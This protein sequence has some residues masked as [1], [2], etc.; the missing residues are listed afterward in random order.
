MTQPTVSRH[1][2][3]LEAHFAVPL[4]TRNHN[5][6]ALT[7]AGRQLADAVALGFGHIDSVARSLSA[8]GPD[9]EGVT[10]GCS[11]GFAS[12]WLIPR[13][14][15]LRR[16]L[17]GE[18]IHVVTSDWIFGLDMEKTDIVVTWGRQSWTDRPRLPLFD[19]IVYPVCAPSFCKKHPALDGKN[20]DPK[21]LLDLPLL[22]FDELDTGMMNWPKWFAYWDLTSPE[23]AVRQRFTNYQFLLQAIIEGDG[24]GLGW[25]EL[26]E[27]QVENGEL[28][29]VGPKI[30]RRQPVY[31]LEYA[32]DHPKQAS[33]NA[34][35]DWFR[36]AVRDHQRDALPE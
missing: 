28:V 13:F 33:I 27:R 5:R 11:F 23:A 34:I 17:D 22:H 20:Q 36:Q 35:V 29:R 3:N 16:A 15:N 6:I 7:E 31:S 26:I 10:I 9:Q 18:Q 21:V 1:I 2:S 14:S 30:Q 19:E 25:H 4:F 12:Q 8:V 24:V 32:T